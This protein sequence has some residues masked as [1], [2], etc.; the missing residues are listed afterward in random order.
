MLW[1]ADGSAAYYSRFVVRGIPFKSFYCDI[2]YD[3]IQSVTVWISLGLNAANM[4]SRSLE[5][6]FRDRALVT[7]PL[8][9]TEK[10]GR[11]VAFHAQDPAT[12]FPNVWKQRL[13]RTK[14]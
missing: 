9:W 12:V 4:S 7:V 14:N 3:E 6:I 11:S 1:L 8:S 5:Y 10:V 13:A 2:L